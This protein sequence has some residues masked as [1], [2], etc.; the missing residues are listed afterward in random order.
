MPCEFGWTSIKKD[1]NNNKNNNNNFSFGPF[2]EKLNFYSVAL[3]W[4][5]SKM[6]CILYSLRVCNYNYFSQMLLGMCK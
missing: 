4:S 6:G 3:T 5:T 2:S 1:D